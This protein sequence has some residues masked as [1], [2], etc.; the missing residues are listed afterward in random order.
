MWLIEVEDDRPLHAS[1][2]DG[3]LVEWV[4]ALA[5]TIS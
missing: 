3:P 1:V 5:E 4:E 2:A